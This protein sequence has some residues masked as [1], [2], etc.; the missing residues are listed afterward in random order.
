MVRV[1]GLAAGLLAM[2]GLG[3]ASPAGAEE[4]AKPRL[5]RGVDHWNPNHPLFGKRAGQ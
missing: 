1:C 3:V 5:T 4:P 2:I